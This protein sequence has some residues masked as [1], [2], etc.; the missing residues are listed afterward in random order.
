[1]AFK[2]KQTED[3]SYSSSAVSSLADSLLRQKNRTPQGLRFTT[4]YQNKHTHTQKGT[5]PLTSSSFIYYTQC[6]LLRGTACP[7]VAGSFFPVRAFHE[8]NRGPSGQPGSARLAPHAQGDFVLH[9]SVLAASP[10]H[11]PQSSKHP[12]A[13]L[14]ALL[15]AAEVPF[16][17]EV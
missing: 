15:Q 17:L 5:R 14:G 12:T 3:F 10:T 7:A 4:V 9:A 13:P 8:Q 11:S 2:S 6:R 16:A 1:M